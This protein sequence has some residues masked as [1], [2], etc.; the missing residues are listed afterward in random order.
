M[1][2]RRAFIAGACVTAI[3]PRQV[4][5]FNINPYDNVRKQVL[6]NMQTY[7]D[8]ARREVMEGLKSWKPSEGFDEV[9]ETLKGTSLDDLS[10]MMVMYDIPLKPYQRV[11]VSR[12]LLM[13]LD[14][15]KTDQQ[16]EYI[17]N[18]M[19]YYGLYTDE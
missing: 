13:M 2:I 19:K 3:T 18:I 4:M 7:T 9:I 17:V 8:D 16:A 1:M 15:A 6:R 10:Y 14:S 11:S 5:A 12:R